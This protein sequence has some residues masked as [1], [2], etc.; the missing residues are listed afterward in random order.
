MRV[1]FFAQ[2]KEAVGRSEIELETGEVDAEGLWR[3]LLQAY[4]VLERYRGSVRL[5]R[6][7]EYV[8][9]DARFTDA[10]EVAL[11]PPVSGG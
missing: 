3:R 1:L 7:A 5:A 8:G 6:N 4:P 9:A 10:D 2:L 11:I